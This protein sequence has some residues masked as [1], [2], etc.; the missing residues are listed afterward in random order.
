[1]KIAKALRDPRFEKA[2]EHFRYAFALSREHQRI[3][4]RAL[5]RYGDHGPQISGIIRDHFPE[6][7]KW[8]LRDLC[9]RMN[10]AADL[11]FKARPRFIQHA[12]MRALYALIRE[13]EG[14]G[15]YL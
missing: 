9:R 11:G 10:E 5:R 15:F 13:Q 14:T 2:R 1:M 8:R 12:T 7:T 6:R 3:F 4:R